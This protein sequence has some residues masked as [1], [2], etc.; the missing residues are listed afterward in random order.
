[1]QTQR[2]LRIGMCMHVVPWLPGRKL[3]TLASA[4]IEETVVARPFQLSVF[5]VPPVL[6][7]LNIAHSFLILMLR[8]VFETHLHVKASRRASGIPRCAQCV[9]RCT[10][11]EQK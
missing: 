11:Q 4:R 9:R 7:S 10:G 5:R 8:P 2:T 3:Q 6:R 1:M